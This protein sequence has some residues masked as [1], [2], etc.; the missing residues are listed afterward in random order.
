MRSPLRKV[1]GAARRRLTPAE[2]GPPRPIYA[3]THHK[4]GSVLLSKVLGDVAHAF[5]RPDAVTLVGSTVT[6]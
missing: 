3:F 2:P 1:I 5:V 6:A 4:T